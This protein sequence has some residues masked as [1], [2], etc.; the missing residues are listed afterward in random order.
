MIGGK[1]KAKY[2]GNKTPKLRQCDRRNDMNGSKSEKKLE[3]EEKIS[4]IE[5]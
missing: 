1:A 3:H 5:N 2:N 4:T